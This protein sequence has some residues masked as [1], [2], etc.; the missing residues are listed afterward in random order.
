MH[1]LFQAG[2][3][4]STPTS[5]L[6]LHFG[7]IAMRD[8]VRLNRLWHSR[9]PSIDLRLGSRVCYG[10]ECEGVTYAIAIWTHPVCNQLPQ[11]VWL[12]LRRFAIAYDAPK[13]T[14]SRML[15]WMARDLARRLPRLEL[16]IS[17]QDRDSHKGTIYRAAG[18]FPVAVGGGGGWNASRT[19]RKAVRI[20]SKIRWEKEVG[21]ARHGDSANGEARPSPAGLPPV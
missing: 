4:G 1:P 6:Q 14:A 3:G 20:S 9:L 8:A 21:L 10:A 16:L 7:P 15:G 19:T 12:E 5:A 17:Y 18:W 13:N 2:E 11:D